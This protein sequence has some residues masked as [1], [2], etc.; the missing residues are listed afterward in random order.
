MKRPSLIISA[1][2]ALATLFGANLQAGYIPTP[3]NMESRKSFSDDRFGIFI[4]WGIYSMFAQGEW[5]LN[6]GGFSAEEYA[7]AASAFYPIEFDA[8]E[9]VKAIKDSGARYICFTTRHHDGFS[10]FDT[11]A[12]DYNIVKGSPFGRD[13]LKELADA[14]HTNDINLHLYYSHIDWTREDYPGGRTGKDTG[15][16][17]AKADWPHYYDF[18]N[19]QLQELLTNYGDVR[20]IWFDGLWDHDEDSIPF[21]W[22]LDHQYA[23]VHGLQPACLIG[24]NHHLVPFEGEDIQIFERDVPGENKAGLSGQD[25]STLPLETCQTMN[26]KWGYKIE[27]NDYKETSDII[28]LLVRTAGKGANLLLNVG[29]LP[30]GTIPEQ[31]LVRLREIGEWLRTYGETIYASQGSPF[32]EQEWGT[33]TTKDDKVFVHVLE[34]S[35]PDIFI[36]WDGNINSATTFDDDKPVNFTREEGGMTLHL[37]EVPQLTDYIIVLI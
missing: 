35:S 29:P 1:A 2:I 30:N 26:G 24:N 11:Q 16:D 5:Y 10:M 34:K 14:C 28:K 9:W 18:M 20:A 19:S 6:N 13:V 3:E 27:D 36:P 21:N 31:A 17:P 33:A 23:L 7:K 37:D 32:E 4:H 8:E 22:E 15:K 12:S 25:I